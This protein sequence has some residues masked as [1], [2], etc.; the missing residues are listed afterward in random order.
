MDIFHPVFYDGLVERRYE[1]THPWLTF[2]YQPRYEAISLRM[3]EAFSKCQHLSGTPLQP[4]LAQRLAAVYLA[5]GVAATTAIEGNTLT[6]DEVGQIIAGQRT[7]PDSQQYLQQEV[8]NVLRVLD[9][10]DQNSRTGAGFTLTPDWLKEQNRTILEGLELP[11]HVQ[12]GEYTEVGLVIG[13]TYRGAPPEDIPYLV[14]R[15]CAWIDTM[16]EQGR[17]ENIPADIA[18]FNTVTT[19]IL[20]HLYLVWIHPFGDGN[21]RTARALES[22]ILASS[23]LVPGVSVNLL[24]DHYN[25]TRS[26]YYQ[27]LADSSRRSD[28]HGFVQYALDGLVDQ[29]REQTS[30]VREEQRHVMWVNHVHEAF[31]TETRG[32]ASARR[33]ALVLALPPARTPRAELRH[34]TA[35]L[36]EMYAGRSDKTLSHDLNRLRDLDLVE[37]DARTG[38]RPQIEQMDAFSPI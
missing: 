2:T 14:D 36:A 4:L 18:F 27:R 8:M 21:G 31:Q 25:R 17:A 26:R 37:G 28:L 15:L 13:Q 1:Q 19:A 22:T 11:D 5:K 7:L 20:S 35:R 6:E 9:R 33:R 24:S 34:L 30:Q 10:I 38:Y 16:R 3:G 29:L 12:P 23:G 32:E